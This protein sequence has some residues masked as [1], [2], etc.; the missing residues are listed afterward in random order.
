VRSACAP[1]KI[2]GLTVNDTALASHW[3]IQTNFQIGTGGAHPWFDY[4]GSYIASLDG[5]TGF[6]LG[7]E[8]IRVDSQSKKFTGGPQA[9]VNLR[10]RADVYLLIDD[11][12]ASSPVML[13]WLAGWSDTGFEIKVFENATRPMLPFSVYRKTNQTGDVSLPQIGDSTAFNYFVIV[14]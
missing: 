7:N 9:V 12:W 6:F 10:A 2:A 5:S 1:L 4:P 8:W 3:A 14:D 13:G 11:R